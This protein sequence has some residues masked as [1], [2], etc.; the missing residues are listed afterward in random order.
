MLLLNNDAVLRP[1]SLDALLREACY[2]TIP[3][4]LGLPQYT[5]HDGSLVDRG[6]EFDLFMNPIPVFTTGVHEV[7]T[8]TGACLWIPREVWSAVGGFP[9]WF[10]SIAEDIYLCQAAR[11]LGYPTRVLDAPGF[12]QWIGKNL[13]GGK[14]MDDKLKTTARRRALSERNKTAVM[15][16]CYPAWALLVLLPI[17]ALLLGIEALFLWISGSGRGKVAR[18]YGAILPV[19]WREREAISALRHQLQTHKKQ[20]GWRFMRRFH[21]LPHKLRMLL[22]HGAPEIR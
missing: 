15:L 19:L 12:D 6:Y 21:W 1:G 17:H 18:I 11:L 16:L 22:R 13:G 14:V 3:A 10:E 2:T 4:V 7:A 8:A 20:S 5:L 9:P